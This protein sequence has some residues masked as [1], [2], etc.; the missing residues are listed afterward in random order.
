[1]AN[2][3]V[4]TIKG[5]TGQ[6]DLDTITPENK[7]KGTLG[8]LTRKL[9]ERLTGHGDKST[10]EIIQAGITAACADPNVFIESIGTRGIGSTRSKLSIYERK[11]KSW[12]STDFLPALKAGVEKAKEKW[13]KVGGIS[14]VFTAKD[15][16]N[17]AMKD[18]VTANLTARDKII[19]AKARKLEKDG[20]E[21][22]I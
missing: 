2:L 18:V 14:T 13:E 21:P 5:F 8:F 7:D 6:V 11:A 9:F 16:D 20:W 19:A 15:D 12:F 22:E 10:D 3:Q 17:Q 1:M 4:I